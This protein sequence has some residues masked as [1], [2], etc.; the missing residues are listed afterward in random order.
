MKMLITGGNRGLGKYL[1]DTFNAHSISRSNGFDITKDHVAI[2]EMSLQYD[3]FV[4]N[5]F[6]GPPQEAWA[7]F[8]Q[9]NVLEAVYDAWSKNN[10]IGHIFNIGSIGEKQV[11]ARE[12]GFETYRV[13]KAALSHA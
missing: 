3:V 4:N 5:A 11:V 12:P 8:G 13:A 9:V 1:T 7:N 2:A 6:D 10:K